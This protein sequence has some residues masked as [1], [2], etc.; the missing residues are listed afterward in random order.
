MSLRR[1]LA[2][3]VHIHHRH[4]Y[5]YSARRLILILPKAKATYE[6]LIGSHRHAIRTVKAEQLNDGRLKTEL[7]H[8]R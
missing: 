2:A 7:Y 6:T 3:T 8:K 1:K 5:Y 4:G